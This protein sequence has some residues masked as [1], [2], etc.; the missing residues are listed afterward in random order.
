MKKLGKK[1][2]HACIPENL[3]YLAENLAQ[4]G[5]S[6]TNGGINI[7]TVIRRFLRL[8]HMY[9]KDFKKTVLNLLK[10]V[11]KRDVNIDDIEIIRYLLFFLVIFQNGPKMFFEKDN[12]AVVDVNPEYAFDKYAILQNAYN[13]LK[14]LPDESINIKLICKI[15]DKLD[16]KDAL[17]IKK[18][19]GITIP[20][21]Q[22]PEGMD[23]SEIGKIRTLGQ[24]RRIKE[25]IFRYGSW[26]VTNEI[27]LGNLEVIS[28]LEE[29]VEELYP[30]RKDWGK[31]AEFR[32]GQKQLCTSEGLRT[33]DVYSISGLEFTDIYE[34]MFLYLNVI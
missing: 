23:I 26:D 1:Q 17:S 2:T 29:F 13:Q 34:V 7:T 28:K 30:I 18:G 4:I 24:V 3:E 31:I 10:K 6:R 21:S 32:V 25:R 12:M 8:G 20:K 19:F 33:I 9:D 22:I 16:F 11:D 15:V 14:D 27:I 5:G